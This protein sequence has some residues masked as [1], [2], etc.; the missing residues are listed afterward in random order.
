M[1]IYL[2]RHSGLTNE[3]KTISYYDLSFIKRYQSYIDPI[4]LDN[5]EIIEIEDYNI[6]YESTP[7][8]INLPTNISKDVFY[9]KVETDFKKYT[10]INNARTEIYGKY[11]QQLFIYEINFD[12]EFTK[13]IEIEYGVAEFHNNEIINIVKSKN[14]S[15]VFEPAMNA[16]AI[17]PLLII[18]GQGLIY[19]IKVTTEEKRREIKNHELI[20]FIDHEKFFNTSNFITI[21][22]NNSHINIDVDANDKRHVYISYNENNNK[23]SLA[24][25]NN[26]LEAIDFNDQI[27]ID[28]DALK[29]QTIE[30]IPMLIEYN[31]DGEKTRVSN[32]SLV[33]SEVFEFQ[34]ETVGIRFVIRISGHGNI[35]LNHIS[36]TALSE[37]PNNEIV[38]LESRLSIAELLSPEMK[39]SDFKVVSIMDVFTYN[40]FAPEVNMYPLDVDKWKS[41]LLFIQPDLFF[42]ESAWQGNNGQWNK[43]IAYYDEEQHRFI[44]EVIAY[45]K[46][47]KIPVIFWNKEDPVHYD[48]FIETAKLCD[49]VFTTDIGRVSQYK[50]DCKHNN[51]DVLPFAAQPKNN[52]PV[53]IQKKRIEKA[54]FAGSYYRHHEERSRDMDILLEAC[55]DRGLVIYDRNY[56]KTSK[57]LMPNHQFPDRYKEYI[58]GTLPFNLIDKSYKGYKFMI[59]VNTVKDS[60]T[61]FSRRVFEG[62]ISGTPIISTYS[63][64]MNKLF[65]DIINTSS[66]ID[67]LKQHMNLLYD[68]DELYRKYAL[69]GIRKILQHH[70]Y[71]HRFKKILSSV[72]YTIKS[73]KHTINYICFVKDEESIKEYINIF[74]N[75]NV[76]NKYLYIIHENIKDYDKFYNT[77]NTEHIIGIDNSTL[78]KYMNISQLTKG[79]TLIVLNKNNYYAP[80]FG[81]D[82]VLA[83]QYVDARIIGKNMYYRNL[84]DIISINNEYKDFEYSQNMLVDR[85][86]IDASVFDKMSTLDALKFLKGEESLSELI[87]YGVRL[88]SADA[89]NFIENGAHST[90]KD[91]ITV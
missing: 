88:F 16:T 26:L 42:I 86:I 9:A 66:D 79:G 51:V 30:L 41:Q 18:N 6:T 14:T 28:I 8:S 73:N 52:N 31:G 43:K 21:T 81:L 50:I 44:K 90:D 77:Y 45:A 60:E 75:Q 58:K 11:Q 91:K 2:N 17:Q 23:F 33:N 70:T 68:D 37:L 76:E 3:L 55:K 80:N 38:S 7:F 24:P 82:L 29:D 84:D 89:L 34:K 65:G 78:Y 87:P 10:F 25:E 67:E 32:I 40:S 46:Q 4:A 47:L 62:L 36:F 35:K 74:T 64:G 49:F 20:N 1:T 15:I 61:M 54:S 72:G 69:L 22:S 83:K 5:N 59:N 63:L 71:E 57:G 13:D 19:N 56:E 39:L 53:K 48:K 12:V 27:L 85:S